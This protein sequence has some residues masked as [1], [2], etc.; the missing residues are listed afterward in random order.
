MDQ[1]SASV[2]EAFWQVFWRNSEEM[3]EDGERDKC[4]KIKL[5]H[6]V[7]SRIERATSKMK[8]EEEEGEMEQ[9]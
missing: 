3:S 6:C 1:S 8:E 7:R 4:F 9:N 5:A 2:L